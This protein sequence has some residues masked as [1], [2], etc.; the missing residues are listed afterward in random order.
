VALPRARAR[1]GAAKASPALRPAPRR[2]RATAAPSSAAAVFRRKAQREPSGGRCGARLQA[3]RT[4]GGRTGCCGRRDGGDSSSVQREEVFVGRAGLLLSRI[5]GLRAGVWRDLLTNGEL[6]P[7]V[8][9]GSSVVEGEDV[10]ELTTGEVGVGI[11]GRDS[12]LKVA[13]VSQER[14]GR[15]P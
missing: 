8:P 13:I 7:K 3:L 1:R 10:G 9:R 5:S 12:R 2:G 4:G 6:A 14:V 11:F 15:K